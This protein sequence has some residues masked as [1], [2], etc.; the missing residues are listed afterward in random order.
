VVEAAIW[1]PRQSIEFVHEG[2]NK[3]RSTIRKDRERKT[4]ELSDVLEI[5]SHRA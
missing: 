5:Q 4:M 1:I 2:C 3:L